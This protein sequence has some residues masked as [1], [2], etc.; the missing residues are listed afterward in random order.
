MACHDVRHRGAKKQYRVCD[1]VRI[2]KPSHRNFRYRLRGDLIETY[3]GV[4][5]ATLKIAAH[6]VGHSH[7]GM[8]AVDGDVVGPEMRC[9]RLREIGG[10]RVDHAVGRP[11]RCDDARGHTGNVHNP[12][13][14]LCFHV[15]KHF[16]GA[17][18]IGHQLNVDMLLPI[19]I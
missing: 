2:D 9:E 4:F 6:P 18:D 17:T 8:D 11:Q 5:S 14:A 13:A 16:A 3:T 10:T 1:I 7:P 15:W 12:P 19:F